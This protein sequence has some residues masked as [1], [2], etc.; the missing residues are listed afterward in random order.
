MIIYEEP[1]LGL[2]TDQVESA[3]AIEH[4][5]EEHH[6]N[7]HKHEDQR[8]L[9]ERLLSFNSDG[10]EA[11]HVV[12][13]LLVGPKLTTSNTWRPVLETLAKR[14]LV[15]MIVIDKVHYIRQSAAFWPEF[16]TMMLFLARLLT[17]MPERCP[18]LLLSATITPADIATCSVIF[19]GMWPNIL[20]GPLDRRCIL[21]RVVVSD[22]VFAS[23][24]YSARCAF[25]ANPGDQ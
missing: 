3:T 20:E 8:L 24:R 22:N 13:N 21:F 1:L 6:G 12:I 10:K 15:Q 11:N 4:N 2:A 18:C 25:K 16:G 5:V 23:R 7:E 9:I 14:G 19:D 17:L